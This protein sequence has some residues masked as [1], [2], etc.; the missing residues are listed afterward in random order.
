MQ[1]SLNKCTIHAVYLLNI[2]DLVSRDIS[3]AT[4][5]VR[6]G[7]LE[8]LVH[9]VKILWDQF[10]QNIYVTVKHAWIITHKLL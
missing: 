1:I 5:P 6:T 2:S 7:S 3:R 9:L 8:V 10:M 4:R